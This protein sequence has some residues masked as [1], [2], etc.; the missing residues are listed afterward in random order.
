MAPAFLFATETELLRAAKKGDIEALKEALGVL[1]EGEASSSAA[2]SRLPDLEE[3]NNFG[4]TAL[5]LAARHGH[6]AAV[7]MLLDAGAN[8]DAVD[9]TG[10]MPLHL[11]AQQPDP[12]TVSVLSARSNVRAVD[13]LGM[14]PLYYAAEGGMRQLF[15]CCLRQALE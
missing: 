2:S 13:L 3:R 5:H 15:E 14:T 7:R 12:E 10:R 11:A 8:P 6:V 1:G 4:H 9:S